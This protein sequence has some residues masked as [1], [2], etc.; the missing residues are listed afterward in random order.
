MIDP[1][2]NAE[3]IARRLHA[4]QVDKQGQ[5]YV[6]H[7]QAVVDN[8]LA[9]CPDAPHFAVEAAWLHDAMEDQGATKESLTREGVSP[10]AISIIAGMS[11]PEGIT[12][13]N[14]IADIAASGDLWLIRVKLA[15]NEHNGDPARRIPGSD[16]IERRYLPARAVLEDGLAKALGEASTPALGGLHG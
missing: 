5:P 13:K 10:E 15:D 14:W 1:R 7:L 4:S 3:M 11:R 9:R 2:A 6:N 12:Y 16:M 8:L